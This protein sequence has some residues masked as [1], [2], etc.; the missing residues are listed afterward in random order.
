MEV[1]TIVGDS[2]KTGLVVKKKG[3]QTSTTG[4]DTNLTPDYREKEVSNNNTLPT[5]LRQP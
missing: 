4:I 3:T 5:Y 1:E 2:S